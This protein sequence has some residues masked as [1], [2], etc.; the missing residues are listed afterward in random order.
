[1]RKIFPN[2]SR[3]STILGL[4]LLVFHTP[5]FS[6]DLEAGTPLTFSEAIRG[7][8]QN[9]PAIKGAESRLHAAQ[10]RITQARSGFLPQ[11]YFTETFNQTTN[12]V[13]VFGTRLNQKSIT[14]PDFD[15]NRL[16]NPDAINNFATAVAVD[17]SLFSG[18]QTRISLDQ[19][20]QQLAASQMMLKR[21]RQE[22][23]A[24]AGSAY[25]GLLLALKNVRLVE[26][27][28]ETARAHQKLIESRFKS[29]FVVKSDL[30]RAQVRIAE[31][32]QQLLQAQ[33]REAVAQ[34]VLR[35]A[36]GIADGEGVD[37]VTPLESARETIGSEADW[38]DRAL[39][40]R[41]DLESLK[42][43]R[44][45]AEGE[46]KKSKARHLPNLNLIGQYE[47]NSEDFSDTAENYSVG[48]VFRLNLYSGNRI[49]GRAMETLSALKEIEAA[50]KEMEL[51]IRV[52]ATAAYLDARTAWER[53]HVARSAVTQAEEAM[54]IVENR[55][56]SGLLTIVSLLDSEVSLQMARTRHLRSLHDYTVAR[57]NLGLA[58]GI[59]DTDFQ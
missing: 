57:I 28:L 14:Q 4:V 2:W 15:P 23:I 31:I 19:A 51:G 5:A 34:A 47:I 6:G 12:P 55:Y 22:V 42:Y 40:E 30:L 58:A 32:E 16:N 10:S 41:P 21:A 48:A 38:I 29:G 52:Q 1:M 50:V 44:T 59:L 56:L 27:T 18:G 53:I 20:R 33:S 7:A 9:N 25:V 43:Q 3:L 35:A 11:V 49:S 8:V 45:I 46:V 26:Q 24:K 37:P 36:M 39:T 13:G 17:W 54:R